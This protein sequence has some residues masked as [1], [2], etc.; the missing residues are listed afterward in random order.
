MRLPRLLCLLRL[1][2]PAQRPALPPLRGRHRA[3][4]R[5]AGP[6]PH[7]LPQMGQA[8]GQ[9]PRRCARW[10]PPPGWTGWTPWPKPPCAPALRGRTQPRLALGRSQGRAAV[11]ADGARGP[12]AGAGSRRQRRGQSHAFTVTLMDAAAET[13]RLFQAR[14]ADRRRPTEPA[15][16]PRRPD[17]RPGR[18]RQALADPDRADR[19]R[20][21]AA[22]SPS[23][24]A[25]SPALTA[26]FPKASARRRRTSPKAKVVVW[27]LDE[28][29]WC[30][31]LAEDGAEGVR[32]RPDA[33]A[34]IRALDERGVIQ[35]IASRTTPPRRSAA[36]ERFGLRDYFLHPQIHWSPK[37]G[38]VAE[39]ARR[40]DLGLDSF[41][42]IDDQPFERGEVAGDAP[43]GPHPAAHGGAGHAGPPLVR[44]AGHRREPHAPGALSGRGQ[45][46]RGRCRRRR[47]ATIWPSCAPQA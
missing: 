46:R 40:L 26:R 2:R 23:A 7:P 42:F 21:P 13:G 27:D 38:S 39:I 15:G 5:R 41:V 35:S 45:A 10:P 47:A 11:A 9:G 44:P 29:L 16:D 6:D 24:S 31:T 18:P 34:A 32:P 19:R 3:R 14:F 30:G 8:G 37:S 12:G 28:T 33:V 20:R 4:G 25:T 17:R 36:L 22:T 1:L 43:D